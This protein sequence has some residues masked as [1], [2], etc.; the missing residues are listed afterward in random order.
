M[1]AK[2]AFRLKPPAPKIVPSWSLD[3]ALHSLERVRIANSDQS[4][5]FMKASFLLSIASSNR[6]SEL[7]AIDRGSIVFRQ[8]SVALPVKPGFIFKNQAQD[9][10]PSEIEIPDLPGSTLCPVD[11]LKA[12]LA[13]T[14][15]S[16]EESLFLHPK[17]GNPLNA[18]TLAHFLTKAVTWLIPNS[19][20]RGHDPR[21]L[22]TSKAFMEGVSASQIVAAGS[23]R[24][25]NTF[26]KRYLV[27]LIPRGSRAVVARARV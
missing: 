7:A 1:L 5:R 14:A 18:R 11:A 15:S 23:W 2:A 27:P 16:K 4:S 22:S 24:S 21:K 13:D 6:V 3:E 12:Y 17:S 19:N 25:S 26:S 8:H 20:P 9:H 10:A